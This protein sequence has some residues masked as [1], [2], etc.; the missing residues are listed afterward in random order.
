MTQLS[1]L[2]SIL[3][4]GRE[5]Q[6]KSYPQRPR[7]PHNWLIDPPANNAGPFFWRHTAGPRFLVPNQ[8][9]MGGQGPST[10]ATGRY[11]FC[12]TPG[13]VIPRTAS[14]PPHKGGKRPQHFPTLLLFPRCFYSM[15]R[16]SSASVR[17]TNAFNINGGFKSLHRFDKTLATADLGDDPADDV[18]DLR[19]ILAES[20]GTPMVVSLPQGP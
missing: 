12:L 11:F 2:L 18:K 19:G 3:G 15:N 16:W 17:L 8:S 4:R 7:D 20:V 14:R 1:G 10:G 13:S 9:R 6:M 5:M